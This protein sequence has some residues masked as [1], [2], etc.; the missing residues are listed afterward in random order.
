VR[1]AT[2]PPILH[3]PTLILGPGGCFMFASAVDYEDG[4]AANSPYDREKYVTWGFSAHKETFDLAADPAAM[5]GCDALAFRGIGANT[6]LRDA[7][8]LRHV[9]PLKSAFLG[10]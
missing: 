7:A 2:P 5:H 9:P 10:R 4:A 6:A 8:A 1:R 3:G